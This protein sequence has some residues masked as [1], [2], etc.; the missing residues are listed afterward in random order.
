MGEA[1]RC[2]NCDVQ[3]SFTESLCIEC[4]SCMDICPTA[5][6]SFVENAPEK[7]LRLRLKASANNLEQPLMVSEELKTHRVMVKDEDICL[8]CG[9]CAERCPT[10]AWDMQQIFIQTAKAGA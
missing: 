9:L 4:D 5:C 3:T 8:H 6:I 1:A 7:E 2:L 10:S